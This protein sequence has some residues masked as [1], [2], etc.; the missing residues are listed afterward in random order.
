[1][2]VDEPEPEPARPDDDVP[3]CWHIE[4]CDGQTGIVTL[5]GASRAHRKKH[6]H[7]WQDAPAAFKQGAHCGPKPWHLA[8]QELMRTPHGFQSAAEQPQC[9]DT[10]AQLSA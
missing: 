1:M 5:P 3:D 7:V 10:F 9:E 2:R 6:S 4:N 8:L